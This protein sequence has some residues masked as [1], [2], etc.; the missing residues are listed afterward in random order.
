MKTLQSRKQLLI[1]E[2]DINRLLLAQ[3]Y[4]ALTA[5]V[6]NAS[7]HIRRLAGLASLA[8]AGM[9]LFKMFRR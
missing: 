8:S 7:R 3:D 4:K 6:R 9:S 1:A 5:D 2:S